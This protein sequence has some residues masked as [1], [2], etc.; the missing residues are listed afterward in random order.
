MLTFTMARSRSWQGKPHLRGRKRRLSDCQ[1]SRNAVR[2][3]L[4]GVKPIES[5][6]PSYC[7]TPLKLLNPMQG[8]RSVAHSI[9]QL[10]SAFTDRPE[11]ERAAFRRSTAPMRKLSYSCL[12]RW[13]S[14]RHSMVQC[15]FLVFPARG[16][17][18]SKLGRTPTAS[19][20]PLVR[21]LVAIW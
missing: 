9:F 18:K 1:I 2:K 5:A 10:M 3:C 19:P 4:Y 15:S 21:K 11:A 20:C 12:D 14:S 13:E 17:R 16:R 7:Q 8:V 6:H